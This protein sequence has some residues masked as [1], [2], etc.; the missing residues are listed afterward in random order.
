MTDMPVPPVY[1]DPDTAPF[2]Y[3]DI[4]PT[5]G[6]LAGVVEIELAAR[7]LRPQSDGGATAEFMTTG[8]LRCTPKAAIDLREAI[9][10]A[11]RMLDERPEAGAGAETTLN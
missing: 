1:R 6:V 3:F 11:L 5:F 7:V 4:A 8:R 9:D 10:K 2:V